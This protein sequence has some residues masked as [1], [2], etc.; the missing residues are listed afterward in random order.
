M[1]LLRSAA[2]EKGRRRRLVSWK[3][4]PWLEFAEMLSL[5]R[6]QH[7]VDSIEVQLHKDLLAHQEL[8]ECV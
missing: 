3:I 7:V 4:R 2:I 6:I 1:L 8:R 5:A